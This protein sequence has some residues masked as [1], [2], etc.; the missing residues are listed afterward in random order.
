MVGSPLI[1]KN[2]IVVGLNELER[3]CDKEQAGSL[4]ES[5]YPYV[6]WIEKHLM[7]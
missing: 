2:G 6:R 7:N 3:Q 1:S 4:F 5:V